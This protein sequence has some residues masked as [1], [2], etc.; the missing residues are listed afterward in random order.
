MRFTTI[1]VGLV[2]T[3]AV[4]T[5]DR[6]IAQPAAGQQPPAPAVEVEKLGPQVGATVPEFT[7]PDQRGTARSLKSIMGP[8]GAIVVFFRSADW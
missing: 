6:L 5:Q 2:A 1:A 3:L 8:K 7:L 4:L